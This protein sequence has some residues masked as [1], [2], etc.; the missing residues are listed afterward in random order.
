MA[1]NI[2]KSSQKNKKQTIRQTL[3][4]KLSKEFDTFK[5]FME[6]CRVQKTENNEKEITH[7]SMSP[8]FKGSFNIDD[9][10][11]DDFLKL[12][13]KAIEAESDLS[14]VEKHK[15]YSPVIIDVDIRYNMPEKERIYTNEL[16]NK[17]IDFYLEQFVKYIQLT[18][19]SQYQAYITE[20]K[21]PSIISCDKNMYELKDGFHI[22][23]PY[24]NTKPNLQYLIRHELIIKATEEGWFDNY[25]VVN[26]IDDIFDKSVIEKNGLLMYGSKKPGGNPYI[27][28][29][30]YDGENNLDIDHLT[31][32]QILGL[33]SLRS[34]GDDDIAVYKDEY[35]EDVIYN[36]CTEQGIIRK[37]KDGVEIDYPDKDNT[38][39][40]IKAQDLVKMLSKE[41]AQNFDS[42]LNVGLCLYNINRSLLDAWINFSRK[43][44]K[45]FKHGECEKKWNNEFKLRTFGSILT[46]GSLIMWAKQD[47]PIAYADYRFKEL[48]SMLDDAS[49]GDP[50]IIAKYIHEKYSNRFVCTDIAKNAWYEFKDHRW[51]AIDSGHTLKT[52]VHTEIC[53]D[54]MKLAGDY[55]KISG[56]DVEVIEKD[57]YAEKSQKIIKTA[58][59]LKRMARINEIMDFLKL[60][61][62]NEEF[63]ENI[64]EN[65]NLLGFKNGILDLVTMEFR[66]G[67]PEDLITLST[68]INYKP[69]NFNDERVKDIE[70]V[71]TEMLPDNDVRQY[72]IRLLASCLDGHIDQKFHIWT[73]SGGNGKSILVD[74]FSLCLGK[75]VAIVD[76][77]MITNKKGSSSA[78]SPD[79]IKLKGKRFA[80]MNEPEGD[81]NVKVGHMKELTGGDTINARGLFQNKIIEFKPQFKLFMLCNKKPVIPSTDGGTWRR[82]RVVPFEMKFVDNPTNPDERKVDRTLKQKLF[83]YAEI[84]MA[85]LVDE[86][87]KFKIEGINEPD[88]VKMSTSLY[89]Q[90]SDILAEFI[91]DKLEKIPDNPKNTKISLTAIFDEYKRWIKQHY[92]GERKAPNKID[93]KTEIESKLGNING[94]GWSNIRWIND[95][96]MI[97]EEEMKT[98]QIK[99]KN[100][101]NI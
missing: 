1:S 9:N 28:T 44:G 31:F 20:K 12:Y 3:S 45:K 72:V 101:L 69:I 17:I 33:L 59:S 64:D 81:D 73:G 99:N 84:F 85:M 80:V 21:T 18:D 15:E 89:Q 50:S 26:T 83:S 48:R 29:R 24:I 10:N 57:H 42:W 23:F 93:F 52:L 8:I 91:A 35:D 70:K 71:I 74:L 43:G 51:K 56:S 25:N 47:N 82:I 40:V 46:I 100:K 90:A 87:R 37:N 30:C 67:R 27:L 32:D 77:T 34:L 6:R 49:S 60:I 78:A 11:Y 66:D 38:A 96:N 39:D 98:E 68:E 79:K 92:S 36:I 88:K 76:T 65:K 53:D 7:V 41:R 86:Y 19:D 63:L 62:Y 75:Y 97:E 55:A 4:P 2:N 61:F 95:I 58:Q 13:I 14:I 54:Y 22:Q 16:I 94:R 5:N